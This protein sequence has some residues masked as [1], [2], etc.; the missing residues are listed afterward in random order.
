MAVCLR[1]ILPRILF[2]TGLYEVGKSGGL[3][4]LR[5]VTMVNEFQFDEK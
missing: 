3:S 2:R 5:T 1:M 4:G